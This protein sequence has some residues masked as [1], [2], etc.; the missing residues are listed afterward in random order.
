MSALEKRILRKKQSQLASTQEGENGAEVEFG[1]QKN[2]IP[3][4]DWNPSD[5]MGKCMKFPFECLS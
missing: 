2:I 4:R 1:E 5:F 3:F